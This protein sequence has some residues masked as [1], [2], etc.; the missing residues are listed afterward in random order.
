M[1]QLAFAYGSFT[2][3]ISAFSIFSASEMEAELHELWR[4]VR[5][6]GQLAITTRGPS[7]FEPGLTAG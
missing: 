6:S 2:L 5:T 4:L 3:V 1:G 7:A